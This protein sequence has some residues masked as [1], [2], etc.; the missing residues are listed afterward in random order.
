ME[1]ENRLI[2]MLEIDV[3][4]IQAG[5]AGGVTTPELVA[6]VSNAGGLGSLGAGYMTGADTEQA[7]QTI[8]TLTDR[9]FAVNVFVPENPEIDANVLQQSFDRL[10]YYRNELNLKEEIPTSVDSPFED[11]IE[12]ILNENVPVCS[13]TFGLPSKDVVDRLKGN[14]V[15]LIGT[16]TTVQE[17]ILNEAAGLD[18]IVAQGCEAGGHRGTFDVPFQQ[19]MIGTMA[20]IPQIVDHVSIPVVAAGGIMDGRGLAAAQML[21]ADGVQMGTAFVTAAESGAKKLHKQAI[22]ESDEASTVMTCAFSGKPARGI[23]NAFTH[24]M[25][26]VMPAP[27]P[28]QNKMTKQIRKEAAN[29]NRPEW[30][31]LWSGQGLRLSREESAREIMERVVHQ[32]EALLK[33]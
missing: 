8:R 9:P 5:M 19:A 22:L 6:A 2:Q 27:Y 4:I 13:F 30:M 3:P 18:L 11:Q 17:A 20:L 25:E 10:E 21:G 16:A 12:V 14:G 29:Q 7:I 28:L 32:Y 24:E 33:R 26:K 31:S 15:I 23:A 1:R